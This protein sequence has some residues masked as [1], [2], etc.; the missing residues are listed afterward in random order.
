MLAPRVD[1]ARQ[2]PDVA[3]HAPPASRTSTTCA[4]QEDENV[5]IGITDRHLRGRAL[6]LPTKLTARAQPVTAPSEADDTSRAY[7]PRTPLA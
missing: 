5:A 1:R 3:N 6:D 4:C 7:L 2:N